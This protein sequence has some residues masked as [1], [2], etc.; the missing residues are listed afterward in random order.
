MASVSNQSFLQITIPRRLDHQATLV[1]EVSSDLVNWN[2]GAGYTV[3][4]SNAANAL[5]VRD[6][7]PYG[8]ENTKRFMRLKVEN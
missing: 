3:E 1:V 5:V 8:A 2:S 4:M 7:T 6:A